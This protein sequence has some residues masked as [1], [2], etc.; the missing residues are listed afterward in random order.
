M[1][2]A[3]NFHLWKSCNMRCKFCFATFQDVKKDILPKGCLPKEEATRVVEQLAELGFEKITFAGGEPTLCPWLTTLISTAKEAGMTTM[4]VTN[5]SGIDEEFLRENCAKLDWIALSIDSLNFETNRKIGRQM[6]SA[7]IQQVDYWS[8]V[9]QI[10]SYGYGLK[11]N[12][13]VNRKNV[14][15]DMADFIR[16]AAPK[17]WKLF[18]VLP[19]KGQNDQSIDDFTITT[20]EFESFLAR[21]KTLSKVTALVPESNEVM[22]GSYVMVDPAG[23]FF[24]NVDGTHKYSKPILDVGARLAIQQVRTDFDKFVKRGGIYLWERPNHRKITLSGEVASGKTTV[25][26]IIANK[27]GFEFTSIGEQT[28]VRAESMGL[29]IAEFQRKCLSNPSLDRELDAA[30][31]EYCNTTD[32]LVIDY[33]LGFHFVKNSFHVFLRISEKTAVE[34]IKKAGRNNETH[35]TVDERN[36]SFKKQFLSAYN[37]DYTKHDCYDLIV[38]VEDFESPEEIADHILTQLRTGCESQFAKPLESIGNEG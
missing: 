5:G 9:N 18:Q 24:D 22:R 15:E 20:G 3:V 26:K 14:D 19:M 23:R 17:R 1:I 32:K 37:V 8:L 21:H 28:R 35:V 29:S 34:R 4:I 25:G 16:H 6:S 2:P 33:R 27:I 10:K 36:Q 12:T 30:F 38:D 13:V 7:G 31:S 11:I